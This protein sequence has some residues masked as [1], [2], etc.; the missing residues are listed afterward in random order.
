MVWTCS[1]R[2]RKI[3][4]EAGGGGVGYKGGPVGRT[5]KGGCAT[6]SARQVGRARALRRRAQPSSRVAAKS[7]IRRLPTPSDNTPRTGAPCPAPMPRQFDR[8]G[9]AA[10]CSPWRRGCAACPVTPPIIRRCVT[11]QAAVLPVC[12]I[13]VAVKLVKLVQLRTGRSCSGFMLGLL[14]S[15]SF[16]R[17]EQDGGRESVWRERRQPAG[18]HRG[19]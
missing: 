18:L 14:R 9:D 2:E 13:E 15:D 1:A 12:P 5:Q 10:P 19:V 6:S 17:T 16:G 4:W 8:C 11:G 7:S 3:T